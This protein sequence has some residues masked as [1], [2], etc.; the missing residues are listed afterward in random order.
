MN[1]A[2]TSG[3]INFGDNGDLIR[4]LVVILAGLAGFFIFNCLAKI[5]FFFL[6]GMMGMV[7]ATVVLSFDF[8]SNFL[9]SDTIRFL[10]IG[11]FVLVFGLWTFINERVI[12]I[13]SSCLV[14][15]YSIFVGVDYWIESGFGAFLYHAFYLLEPINFTTKSYAMMAGFALV[16]GM[17]MYYQFR[18]ANKAN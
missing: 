12:V 13:I 11:M 17:G 2:S 5:A 3:A 1:G 7:V 10:F 4:F 18:V 8:V 14:G 9:K 16:A 15:S 6:G